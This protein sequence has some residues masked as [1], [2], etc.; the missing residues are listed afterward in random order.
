MVNIENYIGLD[1]FDIKILNILQEDGRAS[2]SSIAAQ[3]GMSIPAV[4]ERIKKLVES[5]VIRRFQ[6]IV[7][8]RL[9]GLDVSAI[10][11][12]ISESSSHYSQVTENANKMPE[13]IKCYSTTGRGSHLLIVRTQNTGTLEKLLRTIQAWPGVEHTETQIILSSYKEFSTV[14]IINK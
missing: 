10:I 4:T 3:I 2:A 1:E 14:P 5:G 12:L 13:V 8:H 6:A 7:D 9:V 11:T